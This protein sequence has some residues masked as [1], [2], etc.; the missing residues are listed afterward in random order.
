MLS[1][2]PSGL[3][4][5]L[6]EPQTLALVGA[7]AAAA[8]GFAIYALTRKRPTEEELE[9]DRREL[10]ARVG[11]ITD[12][13]IMDTM[14][15]EVNNPDTSPSAEDTTPAPRIIVYN[16]RI[17]GVTYEC[18]QDVTTLADQV[19]GI[20]SDLPVQVRYAPHNP[21]NSIIVADTWSGLRLTADHPHDRTDT[22]A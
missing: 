6:R 10:L 9:R 13:T 16:Y 11:R 21:G 22:A 8:L 14:V 20:R 15:G 5:S 17:A 18:A 3:P 4:S 7:G 1:L 12:G 19:R 2:I